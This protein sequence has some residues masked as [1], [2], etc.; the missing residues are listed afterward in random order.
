MRVMKRALKLAYLNYFGDH[1]DLNISIKLNEMLIDVFVVFFFAFMGRLK[2]H[3]TKLMG[4]FSF[5]SL[6]GLQ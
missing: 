4:P 3:F 2:R 6:N 1:L 5:S